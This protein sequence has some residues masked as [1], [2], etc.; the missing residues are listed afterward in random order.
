MS[1]FNFMKKFM[2]RLISIQVILLTVAVIC[3]GEWR[4]L[5]P[6]L[7]TSGFEAHIQSAYGDSRITAVRFDTAYFS[8]KLLSSESFDSVNLT[9]RQWCERH[10]MAGAINAGMYAKNYRTHIGYMKNFSYVN[11]SR[12]LGSYKA[13]FA[14]NPVG[15]SLPKV[16]IIDMECQNFNELK[17]GYNSLVQ[18]IRMIDCHG[19]NVWEKQ[20][21]TS[22]IAAL[23]MDLSGNVLFLFS[24]SPYSTYDFIEIIK[25]LPLN[26]YNAMYLEGGSPA[27]MCIISGKTVMERCG[28]QSVADSD[29]AGASF[30]LPMPNV[31]GMVRK[32]S[33]K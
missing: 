30:S 21:Q 5:E 3:Y 12:I 31:I 1:I 6:G 22:S 9:A 24:Q 19:K 8:P 4:Q 23:A 20:I 25:K 14:F 28:V 11:S 32:N 2:A 13:V 33:A 15:T 16:Q 17:N 26:I 29:T 27:A 18:N 10:K 7:E